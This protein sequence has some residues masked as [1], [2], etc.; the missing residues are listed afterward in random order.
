LILLLALVLPIGA[1]GGGGGGGDTGAG[2]DNST[3]NGT[4]IVAQFAK[5]RSFAV[6]VDEEAKST[7][8]T[9]VADGMGM[10][11]PTFGENDNAFVTAPMLDAAVAYTV[12]ADGSLTLPSSI[13]GITADGSAALFMES[14]AGTTPSVGVA[15]RPSGAYTN[16]TFTGDYHLARILGA[17]LTHSSVFS[18]TAQGAVVSDGIGGVIFPNVMTNN[19]GL[20]AAAA[21]GPSVYVVAA[22]GS[23]TMTGVGGDVQGGIAPGGDFAVLSGSTTGGFPPSMA[24]LIKKSVAA[25]N[26][27]FSG[28]YWAVGISSDPGSNN[29]WKSF[30]GTVT[31]N[32]TGG[33]NYVSTTENTEGVIS[34]NNG[35][36]DYAV[37]ADG[38][39]ITSDVAGIGGGPF[40]TGAVSPDG[41]YAYL[42][43]G[44]GGGGPMFTLFVRK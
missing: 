17:A 23:M 22:D 4:Y 2:L 5:L 11:T 15:F 9:V 32:G 3:F 6:P 10:A 28:T 41:K 26:A 1:C 7:F 40:S 12:A 25:T 44:L 19:A 42:S 29:N 36:D 16:A 8:G 31:A 30:F 43:G 39:L 34:T 35:L 18:T 33:M 20:V 24:A 13:G 37:Q 38:T 14:S 27:V 21:G